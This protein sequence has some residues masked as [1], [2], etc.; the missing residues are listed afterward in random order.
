MS[1]SILLI[2]VKAEAEPLTVVSVGRPDGAD[3]KQKPAEWNPSVPH[4]VWIL[5]SDPKA[6]ADGK[7]PAQLLRVTLFNSSPAAGPYTLHVQATL[8]H[9][10]FT[11][12]TRSVRGYDGSS[13]CV[14][15]C[16]VTVWAV[17]L[18]LHI[19]ICTTQRRLTGRRIKNQI[20][21]NEVNLRSVPDVENMTDVSWTWTL[22]AA[23]ESSD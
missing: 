20:S 2:A 9:V 13:V 11:K 1:F 4:V 17:V 8:I 15:V 5:K 3:S 12:H 10:W 16:V 22:H 14:C 18:E 23:A 7:T 21:V 19:C 6:A